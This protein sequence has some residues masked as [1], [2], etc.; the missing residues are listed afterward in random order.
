MGCWSRSL[1]KSSQLLFEQ[2]VVFRKIVAEQRIR[3]RERSPAEDDFGAPARHCVERRKSLKHPDRIVGAEHRH[4]RTETNP[5]GLACNGGQH[6]FRRRHGK[7]GTMMLAHAERIDANRLGVHAFGH[8]VPQRLRL[9][10]KAAAGVEDHVA[11]SIKA[12]FDHRFS[13]T[14]RACRVGSGSQER[15]EST[16]SWS[17]GRSGSPGV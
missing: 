1:T 14:H 11:K 4:R 10:D 13:M 9:R 7:I 17:P 12:Q 5:L 6:D 2:L 15:P 8:D 16:E 3:L